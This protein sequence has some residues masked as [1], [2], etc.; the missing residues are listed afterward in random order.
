LRDSRG[1]YFAG[2]DL[3]DKA[4]RQLTPIELADARTAMEELAEPVKPTVRHDYDPDA[5][6]STL[7][8]SLGIRRSRMPNSDGGAGEPGMAKGLLETSITAAI[9]ASDEPPAPGTYIAIVEHS[10]L[11]VTG[12]PRGREES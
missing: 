9:H 11:V 6:N 8:L 10:P 3:R 5:H 2:H 12:V 1:D 4:K 7:F